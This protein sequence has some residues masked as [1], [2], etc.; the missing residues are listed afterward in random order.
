MLCVA[1]VGKV[2]CVHHKKGM[3]ELCN[4]GRVCI[5]VIGGLRISVRKYVSVMCNINRRDMI[6]IT[7]CKR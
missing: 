1:L 2:G 4:I 6:R 5:H 3:N 7:R